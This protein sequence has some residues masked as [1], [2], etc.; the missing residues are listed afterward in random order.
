MLQPNCILVELQK[1]N[2][3]FGFSVVVSHVSLYIDY[4]ASLVFISKLNL[5]TDCSG[6]LPSKLIICVVCK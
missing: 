2:H 3:S 6:K 5:G 4:I 1:M